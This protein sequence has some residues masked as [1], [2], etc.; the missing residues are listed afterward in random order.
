MWTVRR[1]RSP[2]HKASPNN[3]DPNS[4][5]TN[6]IQRTFPATRE[7]KKKQNPGTYDGEREAKP[8]AAH[9]AY[10]V[11]S[12]YVVKVS[13]ATEAVTGTVTPSLTLTLLHIKGGLHGEET[14]KAS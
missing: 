11:P 14:T 13:D 4:N 1:E 8:I 5:P 2:N 10:L 6:Q 12:E 9:A 7:R 3:S